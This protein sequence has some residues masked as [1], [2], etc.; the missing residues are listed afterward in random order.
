MIMI[1]CSLMFPAK[2]SLSVTLY[3]CSSVMPSIMSIGSLKNKTL[4]IIAVFTEDNYVP[5]PSSYCGDLENQDKV[6]R[7]FSTFYC[8][9]MIQYIKFGQNPSF[10][11]RDSKRINNFGQN[12]KRASVTLKVRSS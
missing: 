12:L 10:S 8:V 9:S 11:S 6:T 3:T 1:T 5:Q 7:I 2:P 4:I